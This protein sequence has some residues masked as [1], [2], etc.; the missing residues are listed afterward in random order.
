MWW[1][2]V[3]IGV[4]IAIGM[5]KGWIEGKK[6]SRYEQNL[7]EII[8][9]REARERG[10][11]I[12]Q[13]P[14]VKTIPDKGRTIYERMAL[15][16]VAKAPTTDSD[17]EGWTSFGRQLKVKKPFPVAIRYQSG[18]GKTTCRIVDVTYVSANV[19]KDGTMN[20]ISFLGFCHTKQAERTFYFNNVEAAADAKTGKLIDHFGIFVVRAMGRSELVRR[21]HG[22]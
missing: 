13:A 7:K 5:I 12:P 2:L 21:S 16:H 9:E 19:H 10:E 18:E 22:G 4:L 20:L 17:L 11:P 1:I 8:A 15:E 6:P 3:L 14:I